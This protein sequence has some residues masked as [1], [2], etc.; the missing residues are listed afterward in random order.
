MAVSYYEVKEDY[1]SNMRDVSLV[2]GQE[3]HDYAFE[4]GYV[5]PDTIAHGRGGLQR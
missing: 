1:F 5:E 4:D 2:K 3:I